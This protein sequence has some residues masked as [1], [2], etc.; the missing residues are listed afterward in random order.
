M[1]QKDQVLVANVVVTNLTQE[2][3]VS[4]VISWP[5]SA[6]A[7]RNAIAKIYKY[8]RL[9]E[10]HHFI[11]MAMEVHSAC[12][13]HLSMIWIVSSKYVLVFSTINDWKFIYLCIFAINFLNNV[14]MLFFKVF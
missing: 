14:L 2:I 9:H 7:K 13:V 3:V 8:K 10:E 5:A 11:L 4:K 1:T 12:I 6:A